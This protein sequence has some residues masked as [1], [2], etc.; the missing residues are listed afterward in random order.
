MKKMNSKQIITTAFLAAV[1]GVSGAPLS[2]AAVDGYSGQHNNSWDRDHNRRDNDRR[3]ISE[4]Q[5]KRIAQSIF[6]RKH[7]V[8]V[9]LRGDDGRREY[10]VRFADGSR[11]D[12]RARDGRV[13]FVDNNSRRY[14][15]NDWR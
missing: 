2:A 6:P 5:A 14:S 9:V 12:V 11:V 1:V 10:Q 3:G 13:T 8:R 4:W 15:H 7:I